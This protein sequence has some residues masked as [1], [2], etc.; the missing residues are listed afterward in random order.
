MQSKKSKRQQAQAMNKRNNRIIALVFAAVVFAIV[1]MFFVNMYQQ[2]G[3]RVYANGRSAIILQTNG[4]FRA[5]L[6]HNVR[7]NGTFSESEDN[8]III[9][10]FDQNGETVYGQI[11]NN[12][13]IIPAEWDDGCGHGRN[14]ILRP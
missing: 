13:L 1:I 7:M 2:R 9:V 3:N 12:T 11:I 8:G 4:R 6:P 10:N 14:F 5:N